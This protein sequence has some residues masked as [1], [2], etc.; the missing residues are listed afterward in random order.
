VGLG[1][2]CAAGAGAGAA[3]PG[4]CGGAA[5]SSCSSPIV[6]RARSLQCPG[7]ALC[8]AQRVRVGGGDRRRRVPRRVMGTLVA[9]TS[10][11]TCLPSP[12]R[13]PARAHARVPHVCMQ[14][15]SRGARRQSRTH[16]RAI[17]TG[18]GPLFMPAATAT[19]IQQENTNN[20]F[21]STV[22]CCACVWF[23]SSSTYHASSALTIAKFTIWLGCVYFPCK[24]KIFPL[25][26]I[27]SNL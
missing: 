22:L 2:W 11:P 21:R 25:L 13:T 24:P 14:K 1:R 5:A 20:Q 26:L 15:L 6:L 10:R 3:P 9:D 7:Q 19:P 18:P 12:A 17:Q 8:S 27:T 23:Y 4:I 16:A